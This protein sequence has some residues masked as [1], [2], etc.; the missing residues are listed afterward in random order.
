MP[1][2]PLIPQPAG[3]LPVVWVRTGDVGRRAGLLVWGRHETG[4]HAG[5]C[6]PVGYAPPSYRKERGHGLLVT[7]WAPAGDVR[8]APGEDYRRVP[9]VELVGRPERWPAL[10]LWHPDGR[11]WDG[12]VRHYPRPPDGPGTQNEG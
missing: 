11:P 9:R 12:R 2:Q 4:W 8:A 10:P 6:W 3:R 5:V 7:L 1:P